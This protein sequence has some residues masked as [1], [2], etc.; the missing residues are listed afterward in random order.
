[1]KLFQYCNNRKLSTN[2]R[3]TTVLE[4]SFHIYA[5]PGFFFIVDVVVSS[6]FVKSLLFQLYCFLQL[7]L[8]KCIEPSSHLDTDPNY[9]VSASRS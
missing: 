9:S 4:K 8:D 2:N 3:L 5:L 6:L 7:V 1:M